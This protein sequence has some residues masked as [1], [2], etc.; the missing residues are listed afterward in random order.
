MPRLVENLKWAQ[1][2]ARSPWP[3]PRRV[4]GK[5]AAGLRYERLLG[6]ELARRGLEFEH[7]PWIEFEDSHGRGFAQPDFLVFGEGHWTL[8]EA[9]LSQTPTAFAQLFGL[10]LPL[11]CLLHPQ[12]QIVPV[13]VCRNLR[14]GGDVVE[15]FLGANPGATWH[16]LGA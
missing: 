6:E 1:Y 2:A 12:V 14:Q 10:Y 15:D 3:K 16:W 13:Q 7:G 5:K 4:R 11:L 8:L 9:K